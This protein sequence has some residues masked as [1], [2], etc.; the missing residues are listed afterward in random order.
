MVNVSARIRV[1]DDLASVEGHVVA[2]GALDVERLRLTARSGPE[3]FL[4]RDLEPDASAA[5]LLADPRIEGLVVDVLLRTET[6]ADVGLDDAHVAPGNAKGLADDAAH[7]VR[8]LRRAH[9]DDLLALHVAVGDAGLDVDLRLLAALRMDGDVMIGG[10]LEGLLHRLVA[11]LGELVLRRDRAGVGDDVVRLGLLDGHLG[12][13]HGLDRVVDDGILLVL[14]LD[15]AQR[16]ITSDGV[17]AHHDGDV[18][19]ID[20]HAVVKQAT[21]SLVTLG[22]GGVGIPGVAGH[23]IRMLGHVEACVDSNDA[24]HLQCLRSVNRGDPT[25][26]DGGVEELCLKAR[27]GT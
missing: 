18:V 12:T 21:V 22:R 17:L 3:E 23:G 14:D 5:E 1:R 7:D 2:I 9:T 20:A 11:G 10:I 13:L 27:L 19:A 24:R 16:A 26:C 4:A 8:N 6:T 15:Q 25:V